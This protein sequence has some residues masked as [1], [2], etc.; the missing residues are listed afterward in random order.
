MNADYEQMQQLV[1]KRGLSCILELALD[2][3]EQL[4]FVRNN[5]SGLQRL[6]SIAKRSAGWFLMGLDGFFQIGE[7][8]RIPEMCERIS[9]FYSIESDTADNVIGFEQEFS[10]VPADFKR[11]CKE[12]YL[13]REQDRERKGWTPLSDAEVV[14]IWES[15][16]EKYTF[17]RGV[18][19][20]SW[21]GINEPV[22]SVTWDVSL[23]LR[24]YDEDQSGLQAVEESLH[25]TLITS[26]KKQLKPG[27]RVFALDFNH[28]CYTF[29]TDNISM[30]DLNSWPITVLPAG[31]YHVFLSSDL[32][33]GIFGHPWEKSLCIF[34]DNFHQ[35]FKDFHLTNLLRSHGRTSG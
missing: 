8:D 1:E 24:L 20:K 30:H 22:N 25:R 5:E 18:D 4:T 28:Q 26:L 21:P 13:R 2:H 11:W 16:T 35:S 7:E 15:F 6:F 19:Q 33:F 27:D 14:S 17:R 32:G 12:G 29:E 3:G 31:D 34:G 10:L 9:E 23:L